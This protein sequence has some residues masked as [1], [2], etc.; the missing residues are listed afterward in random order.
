MYSHGQFAYLGSLNFIQNEGLASLSVSQQVNRFFYVLLFMSKM[1]NLHGLLIQ[2][3]ISLETLSQLMD[4]IPPSFTHYVRPHNITGW[5]S[6]QS[7]SVTILVFNNHVSGT[8]SASGNYATELLRHTKRY[9][10]QPSLRIM[11]LGKWRNTCT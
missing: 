5:M 11:E 1:Y 7:I 2:T 8:F 6:P 9:N 3:I 4:K 10:T